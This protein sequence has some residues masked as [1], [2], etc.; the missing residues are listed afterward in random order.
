MRGIILY[1]LLQIISYSMSLEDEK[2]VTA[3]VTGLFGV[4]Q[5]N[6]L[7]VVL[8]VVLLEKK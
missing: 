5:S 6:H 7:E 8:L 3:F 1:P 4:Q 2:L